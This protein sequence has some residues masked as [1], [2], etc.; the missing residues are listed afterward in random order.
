MK[1][2]FIK[3]LPLILIVLIPFVYLAA[4]WNS[5]PAQIPMH[6][7]INGDIDRYG[8]K[9][10]III[11]PFM[12]PVLAYL[13]FLVMP[14]IDPKKKIEK[15]GNKY[16]WL[17]YIFVIAFSVLATYVIYMSQVAKESQPLAI[18]MILGILFAVLGNYFQSIKS[19]YFIG[20]R[21]PW[22]LES[23]NVWKKTHKLAGKIWLICGLLLVLLGF[24]LPL[25]IYSI[26]F[27]ICAVLMAGIPIVYSYFAFK[28]EN[29][30]IGKD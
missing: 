13:I 11:I 23:E 8:N 20:I 14:K 6:Y 25:K 10:E 22:T 15:M 26:L 29:N 16:H 28:E 24:I 21:T 4:I 12:L 30:M 7:N 9:N 27:I 2:T 5:L 18:F 1:T 3:E 17:R 19:N